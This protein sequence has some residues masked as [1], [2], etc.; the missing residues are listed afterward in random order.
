MAKVAIYMRVSTKEQDIGSQ[1]VAIDDYCSRNQLEVLE[2]YADLGVSGT[3]DSRPELDRLL[4][5]MRQRKFD[6]IVCFKLDRLARSLKNLI[7]LLGE[8]KNKGIR[9]ISVSDN[10]DTA[11]DSPM[12]KAF[13]QLLGVF[14]ELEREI[15][16]ERVRAGLDRV[17]KE[18]RRLGRPK[19]SRDRRQRAVAGYCLRYLNKDRDS[20]KLGPRKKLDKK[21]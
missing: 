12:N 18:G 19:G 17:R 21:I 11:N 15:I 3:K 16:V 7:N 13:W 4:D 14:S 2:S 8:F 5:D 10:L 6:V 1:R 9:L 20:R